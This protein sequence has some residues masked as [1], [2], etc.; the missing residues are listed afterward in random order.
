MLVDE[1]DCLSYYYSAC[2]IRSTLTKEDPLAKDKQKV[3]EYNR[4]YYLERSQDPEFMKRCNERAKRWCRENKEKRNAGERQRRLVQKERRGE[5]KNSAANRRAR[6]K[7]KRI[8]MKAYGDMCACCGEEELEFL[9][10]DHI[11]NSGAQHRREI[12]GGGALYRWL[13]KKGFP[14]DNFQCLCMNCNWS[15][16]LGGVCI[17]QR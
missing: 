8:T 4:K 15:K 3:K 11:D 7:L 17:H 14:Q 9:T 6:L 12:M 1:L 5:T 16:R 2:F 13:R 10:I